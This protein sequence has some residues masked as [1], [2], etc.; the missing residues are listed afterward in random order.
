V[1]VILVSG[2]GS[3]A[4]ILEMLVPPTVVVL[5]EVRVVVLV[6]PVVVVLVVVVWV[7]C[8]DRKA[9][10]SHYSVCPTPLPPP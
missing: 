5:V 2:D 7:S 6:P 3:G 4:G 9:R 8:D 1:E 10:S